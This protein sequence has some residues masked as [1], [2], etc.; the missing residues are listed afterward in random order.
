M[1]EPQPENPVEA[2]PPSHGAVTEGVTIARLFSKVD[3]DPVA[4]Y[5]AVQEIGP[6][7]ATT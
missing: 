3:D 4:L 5:A 2:P 6:W 7:R 1:P